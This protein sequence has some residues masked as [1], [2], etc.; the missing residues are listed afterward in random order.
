MNMWHFSEKPNNLRARPLAQE[1]QTTI[2]KVRNRFIQ[3]VV[4]AFRAFLTNKNESSPK[5]ADE[6]EQ[7]ALEREKQKEEKEMRKFDHGRC[8]SSANGTGTGLS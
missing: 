4:R 7:S 8:S 3:D 2:I 1:V 5:D 6:G